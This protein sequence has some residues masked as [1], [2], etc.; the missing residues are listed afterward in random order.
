MDGDR[1]VDLQQR[2]ADELERERWGLGCGVDEDVGRMVDVYDG[3]ATVLYSVR[4][5]GMGNVEKGK[6]MGYGGAY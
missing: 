3:F 2:W 5:Y 1:E 6:W 4:V